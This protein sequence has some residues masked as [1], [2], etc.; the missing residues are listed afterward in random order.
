MHKNGLWNKEKLNAF[1]H[2]FVPEF[3]LQFL[4]F[5]IFEL[6]KYLW[7]PIPFYYSHLYKFCF[8]RKTKLTACL[9]LI[10]LYCRRLAMAALYGL[11]DFMNVDPI[12]FP[13]AVS[14]SILLIIAAIFRAYGCSR[15]ES[16][17]IW[18]RLEREMVV[19][20]VSAVAGILLFAS[21]V[22]RGGMYIFL[23]T[24]YLAKEIRW[25]LAVCRIYLFAFCKYHHGGLKWGIYPTLR[26][27]LR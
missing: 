2:P 22:A 26:I 10:W 7:V 21:V 1:L 6:S 17:Q 9:L 8:S 18:E 14:L 11:P 13:A 19:S 16:N 25:S 12:P 15:S 27:S 23:M 20:W 4:P 24:G 3:Y 5:S